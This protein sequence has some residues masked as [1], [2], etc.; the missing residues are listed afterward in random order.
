MMNIEDIREAT[1][2]FVDISDPYRKYYEM[3]SM[4][5]YEEYQVTKTFHGT[6]YSIAEIVA[7]NEDNNIRILRAY[8]AYDTLTVIKTWKKFAK[9]LDIDPC[10]VLNFLP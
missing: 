6:A 2:S 1:I 4:A 9:A 10:Q 3:N 5:Y 8:N 7:H